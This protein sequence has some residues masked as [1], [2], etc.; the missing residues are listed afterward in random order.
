MSKGFKALCRDAGMPEVHP[1]VLRHTAATWL[2][3][4]GADL[5]QAAGLLGMTP[6][7]LQQVY[8]HHHP[9]MQRQTAEL[10]ATGS[11]QARTF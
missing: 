5:W 4:K 10:L 1:H 6:Q 11:P 9:G 2:M 3:Q 8:G 7:T